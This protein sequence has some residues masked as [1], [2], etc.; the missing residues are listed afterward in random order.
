MDWERIL[1]G[2]S[3]SLVSYSWEIPVALGV[4]M[5]SYKIVSWFGK[6]HLSD[7]AKEELAKWLLGKYESSWSGQFCV[8]FDSIFGSN[9]LSWKCFRRSSIASFISVF[10]IYILLDAVLGFVDVN[11]RAGG[12]ISLPVA[13]LI[14]ILINII[15]DYL[16]LFETRW[17]LQRFDRVSSFF[18]QLAL[19]AVD[20]LVTVGIIWAH[21]Y[22]FQLVIG[23]ALGLP[24]V[25]LIEAV[26][27]FS[28]Y[29]IFFY[30]T[31]LTSFWA[32]VF[33]L[34]TWFMRMFCRTPLQRLLRNE[35]SPA[36]QVAL[37]GSVLIFFSV[38]ATPVLVHK[39]QGLDGYLCEQFPG[40]I[41][42]HLRRLT[43]DQE[44]KLEILKI[45]CRANL[46]GDCRR[47]AED[48]YSGSPEKSA[49]LFHSAC[50]GGSAFGCNWLGFMYA[51]GA[52]VEKD[53]ARAAELYRQACD[54]G[55][56]FG[57]FNLGLMYEKFGEAEEDA[58]RAAELYRQ[59]CDGG[60]MV[61]CNNLGNMYEKGTG[62]E[63]DAA[64]AVELYRQACDGGKMVSCGNLGLM[65][66]KGT[67]V[68]KDAARAAELYRQACDGRGALACGQPNR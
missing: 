37:V 29:S 42:P 55:E 44:E 43:S 34:S 68:E 25:N 52:G 53:A 58:A 47:I 35:E 27:F 23:P 16:S 56:M 60:K 1:T 15:P 18:G 61:G 36:R 24:E 5:G 48:T 7:K 30:S 63:K 4:A 62:V 20:A 67:G 9:H 17:L 39:L 64:R 50:L 54:G 57:C 45:E 66:E 65:Y 11:A 26:L 28:V 41:C 33:C 32:W 46:P 19:L 12:D 49:E 2:I 3:E 38:L 14:G 59:A 8:F 22:L 10:V 40:S 51:E 21:I 31:F 6:E 13:L